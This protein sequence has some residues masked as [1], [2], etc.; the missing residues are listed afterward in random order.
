MFALVN[1]GRDDEYTVDE[2]LREIDVAN[3]NLHSSTDYTGKVSIFHAS[4]A[5]SRLLA[6]LQ[7]VSAACQGRTLR[8]LRG[9]DGAGKG[10]NNAPALAQADE[11][12]ESKADSTT[13]S[14]TTPPSILALRTMLSE[15]EKMIDE[16]PPADKRAPASGG[17]SVSASSAS[18]GAAPASRFGSPAFRTFLTLLKDRSH[19]LIDAV[20]DKVEPEQQQSW[21][22]MNAQPDEQAKKWQEEGM[23][24]LRQFKEQ[25]EKSGKGPHKHTH[26]L[27]P[28]VVISHGAPGKEA[29]T[30]APAAPSSSSSS[31]A[32]SSS[33]SSA[34]SLLA[35]NAPPSASPVPPATSDN[36]SLILHHLSR[37]LL[38]SFG[39]IRRLDYGT[40]HELNFMCFLYA[41]SQC[42]V[43][44]MSN[45]LHLERVVGWVFDPYVTL[46]RKLQTTYWLEPAGSR[47]VWGLDDYCFLPFLFG[48]SQLIGHKHIKPKSVRYQEILDGFSG[49][50]M[51]LASIRFIMSVKTCSFAEHSP[52]LNDI[53]IIKIWNIVHDGLWRM[54][55]AEVLGKFA[56]VQH[57]IYS[58]FLPE[59]PV[60]PVEVEEVKEE[61]PCCGDAIHF[62]SSFAARQA[63]TQV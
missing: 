32:A 27:P 3:E 2:K 53:T 7:A 30:T 59:W 41:L 43:L 13:S 8:Q 19:T 28:G 20:L 57:F 12:T 55:L 37:Y 18:S 42:G 6:F 25:Q 17:S 56:V 16:C 29:P 58:P 49:D 46:M 38:Q 11:K 54:Y 48:A 4:A 33:S 10:K 24:K 36:H 23:E 62:P 31:A 14:S 21:P 50:Y 34:S 39:D 9:E 51:Y 60:K 45:Q 35:T 52:M 61:A 1:K 26:T 47:G 5:Y 15:L 22:D 63:S 40:G 44:D